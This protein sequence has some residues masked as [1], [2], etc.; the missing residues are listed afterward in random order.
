MDGR[1]R[2]HRSIP[3]CEAILLDSAPACGILMRDCLARPRR[4]CPPRSPPVRARR[5]GDHHGRRVPP[6]WSSKSVSMRECVS[7]C[8]RR[9]VEE[10]VH[11][12]TCRACR[13]DR[14]DPSAPPT[15]SVGPTSGDEA[16]G[17]GGQYVACPADEPGSSRRSDPAGVPWNNPA[18]SPA[19]SGAAYAAESVIGPTPHRSEGGTIPPSM[20]R[21]RRPAPGA[22]ADAAFL[23][24]SGLSP[25]VCAAFASGYTGAS[26]WTSGRLVR[27]GTG[28]RSSYCRAPGGR[29][30]RKAFRCA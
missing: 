6:A 27:R 17:T 18:L 9:T 13:T 15:R 8:C 21:V 30:R 24:S 28:K 26:H 10:R 20:G 25:G 22:P 2:R 5:G 14:P 29:P 12:S 11:D 1:G 19:L 4:A 7:T 3:G 23:G 16:P